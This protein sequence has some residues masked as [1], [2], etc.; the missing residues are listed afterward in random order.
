MNWKGFRK[1][2]FRILPGSQLRTRES[3]RELYT[4]YYR[5][6]TEI[7]KYLWLAECHLRP[8]VRARVGVAEVRLRRGRHAGLRQ[9][10]LQLGGG[11]V[12]PQVVQQHRVGVEQD[13][14]RVMVLRNRGLSPPSSRHDDRLVC[15]CTEQQHPQ[16]II[17][18]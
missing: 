11:L 1:Q 10:L 9:L 4:W 18:L 13:S 12:P 8:Q 7:Q 14:K 3:H 6:E 15:K 16:R 17:L 5:I 2:A